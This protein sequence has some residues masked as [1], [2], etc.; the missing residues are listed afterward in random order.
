MWT[1]DFTDYGRI[2]SV[3]VS[4]S[5]QTTIFAASL[6]SGVIKSTNSGAN[7]FTSNSGL[8]YNHLQAMAISKSNPNIIYVGTDSLTSAQDKGVYKSTD[9][10]A[11]WINVTNDGFTADRSVQSIAVSPTNPD[12]VYAGVFNATHDA[13]DGIWKSTNGG[14]NWVIA[15]NGFGS[16][17]NI[18]TLAIDP[19]NAN[20]IYA[21]TS[22]TVLGSLGPAYIYKSTDAAATWT[23]SSNGLPTATTSLNPVRLI[24][25]ST[26]NSN[27]VC[28]GLFQ[29][30]TD[31]GFFL[32][33]NAGGQWTKMSTGI[34]AVVGVNIRWVLFRPGS[35]T[36]MYCA[37][38]ATAPN[39]GVFR[40]TDGGNSWT[41]FVSGTLLNSYLTRA[42]SFKATS[43]DSTLFTGIGSTSV[44]STPG[45][46]VYE[47]SFPLV[48]IEPP[49]GN[50]PKVY[51]LYPN[52]P[53]PFN[54]AT[55]IRYDVPKVSNVTLK[56]YDI[57]GREVAS[58][59]SENKQPGSYSVT[60]NAS[61]LASGVY[62]YRLNA[63]DYT[64]TMKMI[65]VK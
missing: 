36:E 50:I 23:S 17:R 59:V 24:D 30:T 61:N 27:Y 58:L 45:Q 32:S 10:G 64:N 40:T 2:I 11:H 18:L 39:A 62:F 63:G 46:G 56:V 43:T 55:S 1:T 51:A 14:T 31:G 5:P 9:A 3:N 47:Y 15:N 13:T 53:N 25:V 37:V 20:I 41:S 16:V 6:D 52:Y 33:T 35:N 48:G 12:I 34:P 21:G 44:A 19:A 65:L 60:F 22:F 54:P 57:R 38:D 49:A 29:N 28:A 42:L 4:P 8:T 26:A 7:W